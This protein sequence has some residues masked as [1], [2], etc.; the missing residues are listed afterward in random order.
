MS[1][2]PVEHLLFADEWSDLRRLQEMPEIDFDRMMRY[3]VERIRQQLREHDA[4]FCILVNPISLR[5]AVD[6][7]SYLLFQS[8]IPQIYLFVPQEGPLVVYGCY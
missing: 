4:A 2:N 5:Y 6:Y 7:R 8:H 1:A 3:R